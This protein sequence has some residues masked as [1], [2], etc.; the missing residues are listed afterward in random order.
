[1]IVLNNLADTL[2]Y[3]KALKVI[4]ETERAKIEGN[5]LAKIHEVNSRIYQEFWRRNKAKYYF[6]AHN[7]VML[8]IGKKNNVI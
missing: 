5:H 4:L 7:Q 8:S 3:E 6:K 2:L 1:M